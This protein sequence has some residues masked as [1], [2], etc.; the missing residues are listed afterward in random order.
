MSKLPNFGESDFNSELEF[1]IYTG[2]EI[3]DSIRILQERLREIKRRIEPYFV[4]EKTQEELVTPLGAAVR[5]VQNIWK[6]DPTKIEIFEKAFGDHFAAFI[7]E[8]VEYK[9]TPKLRKLVL[10]AD[11]AL[12]QTLRPYVYVDQRVN[13]SFKKITQTQEANNE[14]QRGSVHGGPHRQTDPAQGA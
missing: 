8:K 1:L 7:Q 11:D 13:I 6:V 10:D 5:R 9:P 3:Q 4:G 14:D 12:G 2:I